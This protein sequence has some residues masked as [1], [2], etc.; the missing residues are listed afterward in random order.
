MPRAYAILAFIAA[1]LFAL[2][3]FF[4][5]GFN[6]FTPD[7]FPVP[8]DNP[9]VQPAG[10]AFS[11]WLVLYVWLIASTAF[12]LFARA[13]DPDWA[14]A[15]P[16]LFASLA[17]GVF[18]LF[19]AQMNVVWATVLI[20]I[21]LITATLA[22]FK[23]GTSD[24][25]L[26][27]EP[28]GA[29]AGWLTAASSVSIGLLLAG[30]GYT[31]ETVAAIIGLVIALAYTIMVMKN[32]PDSLGYPAAVIW[33]LVGVIVSNFDPVNIPVLALAALGVGYI[34]WKAAQN[35]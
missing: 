22:L 7:Q 4:A 24:R 15:R 1:V 21:M 28:I 9:P 29:Y 20:W 34:G 8:Q 23:A 17:V 32:R 14:A 35:A 12:G 18:W 16:A 2:S 31:S 33:A 27:R 30:Y 5:S 6:G 11:I 3:P 19:V 10:Y 13:D 26:Q 25:W